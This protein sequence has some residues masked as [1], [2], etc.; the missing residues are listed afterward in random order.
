MYR[1]LKTFVDICLLE[2]GPQDLPASPFL[3]GATLSAYGTILVVLASVTLGKSFPVALAHAALDILV[4]LVLLQLLLRLRDL[5][6]RFVQTA[7][8]LSGTSALMTLVAAPVQHWLLRAQKNHVDGSI[9][10]LFLLLLIA[11]S[12]VVDGHILRNALSVPL[13]VGILLALAYFFLYML[14][15]PL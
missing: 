13:R 11:W 1:L 10:F 15:S 3:L 4:L 12:L 8:A 7:I 14:L 2:R 6:Q 5:R 9:P